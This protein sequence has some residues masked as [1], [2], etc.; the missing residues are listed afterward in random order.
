MF[1]SEFENKES[2]WNVEHEIYKNRDAKKKKT[3]KR[4][5]DLSEMSGN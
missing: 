3:F 5:P 4:L 1:I 2:F